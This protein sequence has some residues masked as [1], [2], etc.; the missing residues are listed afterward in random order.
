MNKFYKNKR[1]MFQE[2][3]SLINE[4]LS[5]KHLDEAND[6]DVF[7]ILELRDKKRLRTMKY[8]KEAWQEYVK[9]MDKS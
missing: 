5:Y 7:T 1:L 2:I 6:D 4:Q 9:S 8:L 3:E